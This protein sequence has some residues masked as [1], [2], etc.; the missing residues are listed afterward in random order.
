MMRSILV[1]LFIVLIG[2]GSWNCAGIRFVI[3]G[4]DVTPGDP[5][6]FGGNVFVDADSSPF[7]HEPP[8]VPVAVADAARFPSINW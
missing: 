3:N 2:C 7:L 1:V 4:I 5:V 6:A 8:W